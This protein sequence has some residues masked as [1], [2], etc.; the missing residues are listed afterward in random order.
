MADD[1][2]LRWLPLA[3]AAAQLGKSTDAVCSLI[4][5]EKLSTII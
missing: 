2:G 3:K 5:R 1:D 4:R